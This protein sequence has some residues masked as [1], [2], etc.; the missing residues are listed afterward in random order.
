V[1]A[2]APKAVVKDEKKIKPRSDAY[3]GMLVVSLLALIAGGV[4]LWLDFSKYDMKV[5]PPPLAT[6]VVPLAAE[7]SGTPPAGNPPAGNPP[8][9]NPPAGN[10][11]AANPPAANPPA[12][13]PPA[14]N[15]A[16]PPKE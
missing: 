15:P 2:K 14:G 8:D 6:H 3:T 4:L 16:P 13:N 7:G 10:P 11:P 5:K 9:A 12:G 1:A